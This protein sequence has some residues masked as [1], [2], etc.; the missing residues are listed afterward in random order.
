MPEVVSQ[1]NDKVIG[2]LI[3]GGVVVLRTDT[4]YG[5]V[6]RA[7]SQLA[8]QRI[9]DLKHRDDVKPSIVLIASYGQMF[10]QPDAARQQLMN[11]SWPGP[12]SIIALSVQAPDWITRGSGSVAYRMP[13][14]AQ[15]LGLIR[16]T[17]PLAA[18]SANPQAMPPAT[19]V[20][21]ALEYFGDKVDI[22]VD[23]GE[24]I[25]TSPSQLLKVD[26]NNKV[27]RLR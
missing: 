17:G 4:L 6:A 12:V 26:E 7:T 21:M 15:L 9:Y 24:V 5:V 3:S 14:S 25:D 20:D 18:P 16:I 23:G 13:N 11:V 1:I 8:V 10:D 22:Y 2:C 19:T 27:E